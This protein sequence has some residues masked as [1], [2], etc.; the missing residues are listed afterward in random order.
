MISLAKE[1]RLDCMTL[2]HML[3]YICGN[4]MGLRVRTS[5]DVLV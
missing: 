5:N 3:I 4:L 2:S 1:S